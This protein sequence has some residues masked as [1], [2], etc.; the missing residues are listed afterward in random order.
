MFTVFIYIFNF[1]NRMFCFEKTAD[2]NV[3]ST[4]NV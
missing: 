3:M 1:L 4:V 2:Q